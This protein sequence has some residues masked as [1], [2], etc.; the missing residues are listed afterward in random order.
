MVNTITITNNSDNTKL[1]HNVVEVTEE[2]GAQ[3]LIS[4]GKSFSIV[5]NKDSNFKISEYKITAKRRGYGAL[6]P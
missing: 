3:H 1:D 6:P 2:N 5:I 4:P